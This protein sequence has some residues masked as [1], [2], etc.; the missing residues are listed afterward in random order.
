MSIG[1]GFSAYNSL[2]SSGQKLSG[3]GKNWLWLSPGNRHFK[4]DMEGNIARISEAGFDAILVQ[5]F[6]GRKTLYNSQFLPAYGHFLEE[7]I[8]L[9]K[10]AGLEIHAWIFS[11]MCNVDKIRQEHPE[12]FNV[13][14]NLESSLETPPY[15]G[16]YRWLCPTRQEVTEYLS[17]IVSEL[18]E[19]DGLDGIHLDY[20]R[21]PDV[22]LPIGLQPKY[23]LIQNHEMPEFDFCYCSVCRQKFK[24]LRGI[25]PSEIKDPAENLHWRDFREQNITR[26]VSAMAKIA[27][28]KNK[29]IS[30]AVF[31]TPKIARKLV[32]QNWQEWDLDAFFPMIYHK[33][34]NR[35]LDWIKT[36]TREGVAAI[37]DDKELYTGIFLPFL[38]PGE[39]ETVNNYAHQ[40]GANGVSIFEWDKLNEEYWESF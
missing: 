13:N 33:Y 1:H 4:S 40:A 6:N 9:A 23:N 32:R 7:L 16:Y 37:S 28:K 5:S 29:V 8:P 35:G 31:P 22:I 34:Y 25:D 39:L 3:E 21:Y 12:W 24:D 27:R 18:A 15:V 20:I 11:L 10:S 17:T 14:R 19:I 2:I 38:A 26:I 30:A 36:A